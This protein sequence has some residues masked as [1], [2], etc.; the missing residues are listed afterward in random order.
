MWRDGRATLSCV[1]AAALLVVLVLVLLLMA[2]VVV[3]LVGGMA[4]FVY[5]LSWVLLYVVIL[6]STGNATALLV[7]VITFLA[8]VMPLP[9]GSASRPA[10]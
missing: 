5:S 2:V 8:C 9:S 10:V 6:F 4:M 1:A 7:G 3:V